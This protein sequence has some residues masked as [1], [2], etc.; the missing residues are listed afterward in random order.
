MRKICVINQKG[1]VAKTTTVVNLGA[2]LA[3]ENKKVLI[4]DLDPQGNINTCLSSR[5]QKTL[6]NFLIENAELGECITNLG[7]NLDIVRSDESLTKA[8]FILVGENGR[9]SYLK[10]K[11]EVVANY[12]YVLLD[13][14]PSLGLLNQNALLYSS[15]AIIPVSTD[16]LGFDALNKMIQ[17]IQTLNG[18]FC[19]DLV[20]SKIVPTMHD[21]RNKICVDT[22]SKMQNEYYELITEPIRINSKLK[23]APLHQKSIFA[24][25]KRSRGALDYEQLV[26]TVIRD[27]SK[28]DREPETTEVDVTHPPSSAPSVH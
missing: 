19:H 27:E 4:I 25:D 11:L 14:P 1:G 10:R 20:I 26:K 24:Y 18:T 6:Y 3:R 12:D 13:C 22:L 23:E 21:A 9:E 16:P 15:E 17:V 2:G 8:E 5:S 7:R 28:Y